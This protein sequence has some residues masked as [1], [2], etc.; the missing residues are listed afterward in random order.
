[1]EVRTYILSQE[2]H[3]RASRPDSEHIITERYPNCVNYMVT[4]PYITYII[5]RVGSKLLWIWCHMAVC[6]YV[7][8]G[9]D[10]RYYELRQ[11]P[12]LSVRTV[13][14]GGSGGIAAMLTPHAICSRR[15]ETVAEMATEASLWPLVRRQQGSLAQNRRWMTCLLVQDPWSL[16]VL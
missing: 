4:I 12:A 10:E 11:P 2:C 13:T 8:R 14:F 5:S 6:P 1:M 16:L 3:N 9:P 7:T 15:G